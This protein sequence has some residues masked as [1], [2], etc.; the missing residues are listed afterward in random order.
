[1]LQHPKVNQVTVMLCLAHVMPYL[2][3]CV[4]VLVLLCSRVEKLKGWRRATKMIRG[5]ENLPREERF[6]EPGFFSLEEK[7]AQVI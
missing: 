6:E 3:Y 2:E 1:M 4:Q 5:F 7:A